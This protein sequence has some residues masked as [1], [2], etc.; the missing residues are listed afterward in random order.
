[1]DLTG[2]RVAILV[3]PKFHDEEATSPAKYLRARGAQV[4]FVG[5]ELGDLTGKNNEETIHIELTFDQVSSSDYDGII[6]PG[7]G[8]PERLRINAKV[9][10]FVRNFWS[11]N[12]PVAAI[13]HGPQLLIS[14]DVLKNRK[15]TSYVGI[16]DDVILAGAQYQDS[17]VVIDDQLITS[18]IPADLPQF[19]Q[20]FAEALLKLS[21]Q[22]DEDKLSV[23]EALDLAIAREKG[24]KEF[25]QVVAIKFVEPSIKNKFNYLSVIEQGHFDELSDLYRQISGGK[26]P[27]LDMKAAEIGRHSLTNTMTVEQAVKIAMDAEER[28]FNFYRHAARRAKT[29]GAKNMFNQ[30]ASEE[31][32]HRRLL[33]VDMAGTR[34]GK[35]HFQWA[36]YWD[37]PPGMEDLW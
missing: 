36:T 37:I 12:K 26:D 32:E 21:N 16:R 30:L 1:M 14:L 29:D 8:S 5:I 3:G 27:K 11:T 6:I 15:I 17:P 34:A 2:I 31:L 24:A 20:A 22:I 25:Y 35:G 9:L 4:D 28:S 10:D 33:S 13:C 18:R 7:G 23:L 19:N